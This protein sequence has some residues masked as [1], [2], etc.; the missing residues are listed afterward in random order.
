M[1]LPKHLC[2]WFYVH[3]KG[4]H[5]PRDSRLKVRT[6]GQEK[7]QRDGGGGNGRKCHSDFKHRAMVLPSDWR[8]LLPYLEGRAIRKQWAKSASFSQFLPRTASKEAEHRTGKLVAW[9]KSETWAQLGGIRNDYHRRARL[10]QTP[11]AVFRAS[12]CTTRLKQRYSRTTLPGV[13]VALGPCEVI[14]GY[15]TWLWGLQSFSKIIHFL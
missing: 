8:N 5:G 6:H 2:A 4:K 10:E 1:R 15:L 11:W 3:G 7:D 13:L 9:P 12:G 14:L